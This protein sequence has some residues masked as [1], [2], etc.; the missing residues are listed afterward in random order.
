MTMCELYPEIDRDMLL[1]GVFLHDI[2]KIEEMTHGLA[3]DYTNAGKLVGHLQIGGDMAQ[4]KIRQIPN[5]PEKHRLQLLHMI[6]SHHGEYVNGAPVLPK[7]LEGIVLHH[8][9][10]LD[11]QAAAVSR[12][13]RETRERQQE[14]SE[15]LPLINRVIWT[16]GNG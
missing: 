3:V 14:W 8:I 13:V 6:L 15:F 12:I 7:T 11:A 4:E 16:K 9:D 1:T 5:F 2:G 10:N